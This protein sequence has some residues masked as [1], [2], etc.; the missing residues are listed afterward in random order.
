MLLSYSFAANLAPTMSAL[1]SRL[2]LSEAELKK[3]VLR[4]PKVL[5]L[6]FAANL[7]PTMAALQS[8]LEL[9]EAELKKV[10]L[11]WPTG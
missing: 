10:V 3:A 11:R 7:A 9:S 8:R 2:E 1:Q 6:S 5:S 4:W